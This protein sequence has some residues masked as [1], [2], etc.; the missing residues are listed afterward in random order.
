MAKV[1]VVSTDTSV[2]LS[3]GRVVTLRRPRPI[4]QLRATEIIGDV[5]DRT[6]AML[7]VCLYIQTI[8]GV[9]ANFASRAQMDAL[10]ERL[11]DGYYEVADAIRT[12]PVKE[13]NKALAKKS[14]TVSTDPGSSS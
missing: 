14:P 6:L 2:T 12:M 11:E 8:D 13:V 9:A 3:D 1:E 5:P 4:D 7:M 10:I